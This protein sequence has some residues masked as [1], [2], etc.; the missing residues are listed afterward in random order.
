M[1]LTTTHLPFL[2]H[3]SCYT[4]Y[5]LGWGADKITLHSLTCNVMKDGYRSQYVFISYSS[6]NIHKWYNPHSSLFHYHTFM[7]W[8]MV[9]I[10]CQVNICTMIKQHLY[11][12]CAILIYARQQQW[13]LSFHSPLIHI[14]TTCNNV[15]IIHYTSSFV[16]SKLFPLYT[17]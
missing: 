1:V 12:F 11:Q 4:Q 10:V 7:E 9:F 5:T 17:E 2:Q 6:C 3:H 13:C 15:K 16:L 14:L 8:C